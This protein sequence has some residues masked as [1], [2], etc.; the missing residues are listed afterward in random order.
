M[1]KLSYLP[2]AQNDYIAA[3]YAEEFGFVGVA[4][5]ILLYMLIGSIGFSIAHATSDLAGFYFAA[6]IT[7]SYLLS[8]FYE[9]WSRFRSS[10]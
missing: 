7:F 2:E 9:S 4:C 10:A 5:L 6:V 8:G 1:Q 3:I